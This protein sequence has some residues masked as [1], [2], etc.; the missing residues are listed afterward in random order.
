MH[1]NML[2]S[3]WFSKYFRRCREL[4]MLCS[5]LQ[6]KTCSDCLQGHGLSFV[7][8][9]IAAFDKPCMVKGLIWSG[10]SAFSQLRNKQKLPKMVDIIPNFLVL[11]FGEHFMKIRTKIANFQ[12]HK[13]LHK[14]V[15][16]NMFSFTFLY[17]F[18]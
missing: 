3:D 1:I 8:G 9:V 7:T 10:I 12:M 11:H 4:P 15:N 14:N 18:S 6:W 5:Q 13:T 17:K 16:Q 2:P